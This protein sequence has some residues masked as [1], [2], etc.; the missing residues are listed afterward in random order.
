MNKIQILSLAVLSP[1]FLSACNSTPK[2]YVSAY[3]LENPEVASK[4]F[5]VNISSAIVTDSMVNLQK[6]DDQLD[7]NNDLNLMASVG[8]TF[9]EGL[10][11]SLT[12]ANGTYRVAGK[13]QFF[14]KHSDKASKG[15]F[16]QA[17]SLGYA[18][19][20]VN[21]TE[22]NPEL[23]TNKQIPDED[24]FL[25]WQHTTNTIDIAWIL[26]YRIN[27]HL[28]VYGGPFYSRS[29]LDGV[30]FEGYDELER[31]LDFKGCMTGANLALEYRFTNGIA[32]AGEALLF[33]NEWENDSYSHGSSTFNLK[34]DYQF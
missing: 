18:S 26:G 27:H 25:P 10:Q 34:I 9:A 20:D 1:L 22:R 17:F 31:D 7:D 32:L 2:A 28:M 29:S 19:R 15:N 33:N 23:D 4:P 5:K 21:D 13:Y 6:D 16:S 3:R 11:F 30:R 24:R 8:M 14:G 12:R